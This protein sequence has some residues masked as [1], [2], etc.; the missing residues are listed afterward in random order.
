MTEISCQSIILL[1]IQLNKATSDQTDKAH[2]ISQGG[3]R[4]GQ[5][6]TVLVLRVAHHIN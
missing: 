6:A 4:T 1:I 3:I 5:E 2:L